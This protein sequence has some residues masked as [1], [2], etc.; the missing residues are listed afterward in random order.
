MTPNWVPSSLFS[1]A[2]TWVIVKMPEDTSHL[3]QFDQ[4][5]GLGEGRGRGGELRSKLLAMTAPN[6][7]MKPVIW[8][9]HG[10]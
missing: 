4:G 6:G 9:Y 3:G 5:A 7:G 1:V 8:S 2:S 10:A